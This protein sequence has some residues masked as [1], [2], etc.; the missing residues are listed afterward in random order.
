MVKSLSHRLHSLARYY[1]NEE[2]I[3][4]IGCDHGQLG[5]SFAQDLRV[6]EIHLVDPSKPVIVKLHQA[7]DAYISKGKVFVH[8][9]RGQEIT[10]RTCSQLIFIAGMGGREMGHILE[11][12]ETKISPLTRIVISPHRNILELRERLA[13]SSFRLESEELVKDFDRL[14]QVM[15]LSKLA[16]VSAVSPYGKELWDHPLAQEYR[17]QQLLHFKSHR[18]PRSEGYCRFLEQLSS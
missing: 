6:K 15:V 8:H 4:D 11:S 17:E 12:L 16:T 5:L 2:C 9:V 3:W 10:L 7:I 18:D 1:N 13:G 14:Y